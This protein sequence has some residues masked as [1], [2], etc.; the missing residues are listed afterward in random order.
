[1]SRATTPDTARLTARLHDVGVAGAG[2]AALDVAR[3]GD[4]ASVIAPGFA[5]FVEFGTRV[6]PARPFLR[7]AIDRVRADTLSGR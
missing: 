2:R 1:M 3:D 7:P 5:R 4:G 6:M